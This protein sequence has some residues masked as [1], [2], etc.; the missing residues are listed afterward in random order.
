ME[1]HPYGKPPAVL[2]E[3]LST[4]YPST[5]GLNLTF[6]CN[7]NLLLS[8]SLLVGSW[9][10]AGCSFDCTVFDCKIVLPLERL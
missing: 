7:E 4:G 6:V 1:T 3:G 8:F 5:S 9:S 2:T 10:R